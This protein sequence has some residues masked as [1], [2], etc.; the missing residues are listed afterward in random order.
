MVL[1]NDVKWIVFG[2]GNQKRN[3]ATY[4]LEHE[5]NIVAVVDSDSNKW[6]E[7]DMSKICDQIS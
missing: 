6:G 5:E 4:L 3:M 1:E 2:V 7:G